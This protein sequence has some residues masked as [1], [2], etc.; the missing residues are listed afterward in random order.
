VAGESYITAPAFILQPDLC[1][2]SVKFIFTTKKTSSIALRSLSF[3]ENRRAGSLFVVTLTTQPQFRL[4][5]V[6]TL[7][8]GTGLILVSHIWDLWWT[9]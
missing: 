2:C 7:S 8:E 1:T 9:K 6:D 4:L 3:A 5:V